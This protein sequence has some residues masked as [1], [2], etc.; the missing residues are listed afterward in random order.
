MNNALK[1]MRVG[2][3]TKEQLQLALEQRL[4]Q[5]GIADLASGNLAEATPEYFADSC[6]LAH[7]NINIF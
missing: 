3:L 6:H 1:D 7:E 2:E 4:V 5:D